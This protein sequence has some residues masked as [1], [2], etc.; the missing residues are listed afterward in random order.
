MKRKKGIVKRVLVWVDGYGNEH[1]ISGMAN[2]HIINCILW[3]NRRIN[4]MRSC[5]NGLFDDE[6]FEANTNIAAFES[7]LRD[8]K[9][10]GIYISD[11]DCME[12]DESID[13]EVR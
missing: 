5:E 6:I 7:E 4:E 10:Q 1:N 11:E 12:D 3:L 9:K 2:D 13:Y 8:R